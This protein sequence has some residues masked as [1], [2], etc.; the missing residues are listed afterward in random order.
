MEGAKG[1]LTAG[2]PLSPF[3]RPPAA[4]TLWP[5]SVHRPF[6][7]PLWFRPLVDCVKLQSESSASLVASDERVRLALIFPIWQMGLIVL[8]LQGSGE[9]AKELKVFFPFCPPYLNPPPTPHYSVSL[10]K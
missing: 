7:V 2:P 5:L 4:S 1:W 8:T 10:L 9:D 3:P 6:S